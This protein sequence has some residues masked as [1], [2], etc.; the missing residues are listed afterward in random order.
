MVFV[1]LSKLAK[2]LNFKKHKGI[3][4]GNLDGYLLTF[5]EDMGVKYLSITISEESPEKLDSITEKLSRIDFK[6]EF[7]ILDFLVTNIYILVIFHDNPGTMKKYREFIDWII[8]QLKSYNIKGLSHCSHCFQPF[9]DK[10]IVYKNINNI[11]FALHNS[12]AKTVADEIKL[13]EES[14]KKY[15]ILRASIGSLLGGV[16]FSIPIGILYYLGWYAGLFGFLIGLGAKKGYEI[17]GGKAGKVKLSLVI[18]FT[19]L[20]VVLSKFL[21]EFIYF[22]MEITKGNVGAYYSQI[23]LLI[24]EL[25]VNNTSYSTSIIIDIGVCFA[26]A[27]LGLSGVITELN[28]AKPT[29]SDVS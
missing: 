25:L 16:I 7:R 19:L 2:E 29:I 3:I 5:S 18:V 13:E 4:Y 8:P 1:G 28:D 9:D 14:L 27:F 12:C 6:R 22:A 23:P 11:V 10:D 24:K 20:T 26:F 21:G 15:N 17:L